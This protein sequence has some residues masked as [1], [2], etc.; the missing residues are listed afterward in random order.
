MS[1][2]A[3]PETTT[4]LNSNQS[5]DSA[6][7]ICGQEHDKSFLKFEPRPIR[8]KNRTRWTP[9]LFLL[10][11]VI[12]TGAVLISPN[13]PVQVRP[14]P[15]LELQAV[16]N[17]RTIAQAEASFHLDHG[18]YGTFEDLIESSELTGDWDIPLRSRYYFSITISEKSFALSAI[19][20][21]YEDNTRLSYIM[22][23]GTDDKIEDF[24]LHVTDNEGKPATTKDPVWRR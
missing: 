6:C 16:N 19:P 18:R 1:P 3:N 4:N 2:T 15:T 8:A 14:R 20:I 23:A 10:V 21:R 7:V 13:Q 11:P 12:L 24:T 5:T 17:A 9:Y 22:T